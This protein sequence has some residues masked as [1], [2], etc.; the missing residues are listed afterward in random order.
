[1]KPTIFALDM[2]FFICTFSRKLSHWGWARLIDPKRIHAHCLSSGMENSP[3]HH[4]P[5]ILPFRS[6][7]WIQPAWESFRIFSG[8]SRWTSGISGVLW[9]LWHGINEKISWWNSDTIWIGWGIFHGDIM[10]YEG[11]DNLWHGRILMVGRVVNPWRGFRVDMDAY[12]IST[13]T[14]YVVI[15]AWPWCSLVKASC[16]LQI[17]ECEHIHERE[18]PGFAMDSM[19]ILS[20]EWLCQKWQPTY[21]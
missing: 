3:S 7:G 20:T 16:W 6:Y 4:T 18:N 12:S 10:G 13:R 14:F 17:A 15:L 2:G 9:D 1:M 19:W 5:D 8:V 21:T 11:I